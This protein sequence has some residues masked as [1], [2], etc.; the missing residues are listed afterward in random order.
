MAS[1]HAVGAFC[2]DDNAL[3][4]RLRLQWQKMPRSQTHEECHSSGAMPLARK[5]QK[6]PGDDFAWPPAQRGRAGT[7]HVLLL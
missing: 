2:Q 1:G 3:I 5:A 6:G 4:D 7:Y